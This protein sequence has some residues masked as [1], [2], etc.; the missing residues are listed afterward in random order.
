MS[1]AEDLYNQ[2]YISYPR[3][4]T[5]VFPETIDL[6]SLVNMFTSHS[7][8]GDYASKISSM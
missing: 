8:L 4:E 5:N 2:G 3:T 7:L 1:L 6:K